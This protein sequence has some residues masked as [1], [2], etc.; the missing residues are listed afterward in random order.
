M[1]LL[2]AGS[3]AVAQSFGAGIAQGK[4]S[5]PELNEL[6]GMVESKRYPGHFW[7]HNDSGDKARIFL[8][9]STAR[10]CATVEFQGMEARD[11]ED[12]TMMR[13]DGRDYLVI[14]DIGDNKAQHPEVYLHVLEEP[15]LA[16]GNAPVDTLVD[17]A[18]RTYSFSYPDG[19]RDAE[20]LFFDPQTGSLYLI[21]KRELSVGVYRIG[22]PEGDGRIAALTLEGRLPLTYVTGADMSADGSELLVKNLLEVHYWQR[23]PEETASDM[24]RRPSVRQPYAPEPQGEAITFRRNGQG[25]VTVSE[26]ALGM[27]AVLFHYPRKQ[28]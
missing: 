25:Y 22:L 4:I 8:I 16:L 17:M 13:A 20:S 27:D 11:W 23:Q 24:L 2:L 3:N 7:V 1:F 26:Q 10:H 18:I 12:I 14:G 6:S 28:E 19:P 15:R 21:T 5:H 9:D